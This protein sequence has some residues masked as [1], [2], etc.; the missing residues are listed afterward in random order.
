MISKR[1]SDWA[2]FFVSRARFE[3]DFTHQLTRGHCIKAFAPA[4]EVECDLVGEVAGET[5]TLLFESCRLKSP[6]P[7]IVHEL[8]S[9]RWRS[10][11]RYFL[12]TWHIHRISP[13][14]RG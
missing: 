6:I 1:R 13:Q 3:H 4:G 5:T 9:D 2:A 12:F 10:A 7:S 11:L 8:I 14:V